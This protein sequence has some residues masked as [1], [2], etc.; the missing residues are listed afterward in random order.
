MPN[1]NVKD[2]MVASA[3]V[4]EL[5]AALRWRV[6]DDAELYEVCGLP[7]PE[8][9]GEDFESCEIAEAA[10]SC[11]GCLP[12]PPNSGAASRRWNICAIS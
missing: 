11:W 9:L 5:V 10:I 7:A 6:E 1:V 3:G 12:P 4:G 8:A 2:P